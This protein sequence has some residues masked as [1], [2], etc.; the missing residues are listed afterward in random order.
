MAEDALLTS[1][2]L[3]PSPNSSN[4]STAATAK[5]PLQVLS[6]NATA[7][8]SMRN[9]NLHYAI[10]FGPVAVAFSFY[11]TLF[12]D[13]G[14]VAAFDLA[15]QKETT[16][17]LKVGGLDKALPKLPAGGAAEFERQKEAGRFEM[18]V[19]LDTVMQYKGHKAKCLLVVICP[20]SLQ[21]VDPDLAATSFQK[22]KC[23]ILR[24]K[25]S[26]C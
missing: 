25:M 6:Y 17:P 19:R 8:V 2:E 4:S 5:S 13:S 16:V 23:T 21:L 18:E 10:S 14:T 15:A 26:G 20:L 12:D 22:T 9:P 3:A 1:F 7:A 11:S 24:A